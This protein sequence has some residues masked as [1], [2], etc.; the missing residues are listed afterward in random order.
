M[1][2]LINTKE[3]NLFMF[4]YYF[5]CYWEERVVGIVDAHSIDDGIRMIKNHYKD[6]SDI[7]WESLKLEPIEFDNGVCEIYYGG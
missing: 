4:R 2:F 5:D 3:D 1:N 6:F 7:D